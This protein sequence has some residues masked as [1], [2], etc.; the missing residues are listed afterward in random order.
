MAITPSRGIARHII[1]SPAQSYKE[2]SASALT[3]IHLNRINQ[4]S[5]KMAWRRPTRVARRKLPAPGGGGAAFAHRVNNEAARMHGPENII[6]GII[7]ISLIIVSS[8]SVAHGAACLNNQPP[9][10]ATSPR[11]PAL[12]LSKRN[13]NFVGAQ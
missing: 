3:G 9:S 8:S 5:S 6:N 11:R 1:A 13:V 7:I 2:K 10:A 4:S 12:D